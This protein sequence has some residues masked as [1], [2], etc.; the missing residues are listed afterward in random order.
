VKTKLLIYSL[1]ISIAVAIALEEQSP[2]PSASGSTIPVTADNFTRAETDTYFANI[3]KE[4]GGPGTFFHRR[5]IEP[6]DKQIVIRGN[7]DTRSHH[8]QLSHQPNQSSGFQFYNLGT[9]WRV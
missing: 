2:S 4:A 9:D 8:R 6:S 7:R 3:V 1:G 5:E